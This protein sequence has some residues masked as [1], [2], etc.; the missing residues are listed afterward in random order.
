MKVTIFIAFLVA[1]ILLVQISFYILACASELMDCDT[2]QDIADIEALASISNV[3]NSSRWTVSLVR[4]IISNF[5]DFHHDI[6]ATLDY[7]FSDHEYFQSF[8]KSGT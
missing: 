7:I 3:I 2:P 6:I 5:G 8:R 1:R 4:G